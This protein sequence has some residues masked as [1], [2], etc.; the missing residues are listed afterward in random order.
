MATQW[1]TVAPSLQALA[2]QD[3]SKASTQFTNNQNSALSYLAGTTWQVTTANIPVASAAL[4][5][6]LIT[7][8]D[9]NGG[10]AYRCNGVSWVK[11]SPGLTEYDRSSALWTA[12]GV[13]LVGQQLRISDFGNNPMALAEWNGARWAPQAGCQL[14]YD[15]QT[16][17]VSA[18]SLTP[19]LN[20]PDVTLPGGSWGLYGGYE[21]E[22]VVELTAQT[23]TARQV[24]VN[25]AGSQIINDAS[26]A[27]HAGYIRGMRNVGSL[28]SQVVFEKASDYLRH[29]SANQGVQTKTK[30]SA[31]DLLVSGS[32]AATV[33]VAD[34]IT[35]WGYRVWWMGLG[36]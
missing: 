26:V 2:G 28:T 4:A 7:V 30:D 29:L 27:R 19:S 10:T 23:P 22:L 33:T 5:G 11:Q 36:A 32:V 1:E 16:P 6:C 18:S 21:L 9:E 31:T 13:G 3:L 25:L 17:L 20:L 24:T 34:T 14:I 8:T 15:L 35:L 12:R